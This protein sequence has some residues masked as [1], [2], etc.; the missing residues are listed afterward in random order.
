MAKIFLLPALSLSVLALT[1]PQALW[2]QDEAEQVS[3]N[4]NMT[5]DTM[6][7]T[8]TRSEESVREVTTN[9]TVI[10]EQTI[11]NSSATDV[12]ALL[13]QQ[14]FQVKSYPGSSSVLKIRGMG[15]GAMG[16]EL[17]SNVLVL[18]NGRRIGSNNVALVGLANV[19]RVEV[20]R[21]P[22]AVQYGPA[23][24]GGVVNV[25]TKRG[26]ENFEGYAEAGFGSF[27]LNKQKVSFSGAAEVIDFSLGFNHLSQDDNYKTGAGKTWKHTGLDN[28]Y[29][30]NA[31]LG[32]NFLESHRLGLNFNYSGV[33]ESK[34]PQVGWTD[35]NLPKAADYYNSTDKE[36]YNLAFIY[37][38]HTDDDRFSWSAQYA[39]G[40][41]YR[42]IRAYDPDDFYGS[43]VPPYWLPVSDYKETIDVQTFTA[44]A[45]YNGEMLSLTGGFDYAKYDV[46]TIQELWGYSR[47]KSGYKDLAGFVSGKL[48]LFDERLILSAG[49]RYDSFETSGDGMRTK[50]D[51][52]FSPSV[53]LAYLPVDWLKLRTNYSEGFKVA[54]ASEL[55]Q[56]IYTLP[57]FKLS[58]EKSKTFE[59]GADV[60]WE[61]INSSLT[62]FHTKWDDRIVAAY[63][64]DSIWGSPQYRY[65]NMAAATIAG[66]EF[67]FSADLGQA[68]NQE[69]MLKPY[70][71]L[72]Y[73][74][75]RKNKD[76]S[77]S[78]VSVEA[79]GK[80]TLPDVPDY[81]ISY[82]L[83]F[84]HP[85]Y[86]FGAT[87]N[88]SY[89][90]KEISQSFAN[91]SPRNGQYIENGGYTL[92]DLTLQK[93]IIDFEDKG[94]LN[95]RAEIN[96]LFDEDYDSMLDYRGKGRNFYVGLRYEY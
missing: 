1:A 62:Y 39:F 6:V 56:S 68:W 61:Y 25:I 17:S 84:Q 18:L 10:N 14:G 64:G 40:Q 3:A 35:R 74:L 73:L 36:N 82:G 69:F 88:A 33:N 49:G 67:S 42:N 78:R 32:F 30:L 72:T 94:H 81:T 75:S 57:N 86:N 15:Q 89:Y 51:N 83:E 79:I 19:E 38:G 41:D 77:G 11:K 85:G 2:A 29:N 53:G 96:N 23:A 8:A 4:A 48:R 47:E 91:A 9:V 66:L 16:T 27:G 54:N 43:L 95:I 71:N 46:L 76:H 52:N 58:P 12:G 60:A 24:M 7:V 65:E 45:G 70:L 26:T 31:D 63:A 44:Q 20:I 92:V 37:E 87:V 5:L 93:R 13:K 22:S 55:S 50:S 90:G 21:G 28:E 80:D 34:V 59:I